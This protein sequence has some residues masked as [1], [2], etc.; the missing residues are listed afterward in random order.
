MIQNVFYIEDNSIENLKSLKFL[1]C[2][3]GIYVRQFPVYRNG[4]YVTLHGYFIAND[5]DD[6][7][8]IDVI[9]EN[10]YVYTP[11]YIEDKNNEVIKIVKANIKKEMD[12]CGIREKNVDNR[13]K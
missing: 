4:K 11:F 3:N 12:L 13:K 5:E 10:G 6:N 7:I 8:H 2:G 1:H 9:D